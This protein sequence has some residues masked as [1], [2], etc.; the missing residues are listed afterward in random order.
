[1]DPKQM[2]IIEIG[3]G[4]GRLTQALSKFFGEVHALDVSGEMVR[5][6]KA[7]L[8]AIVLAFISTRA[9]AATSPSCLLDLT[10]SLTP[11]LCSNTFRAA[12]LSKI[13]SAK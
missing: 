2:R 3:C 6:A 8:W 10:I 13:T 7:A 1:M 5:Q 11:R 12:R 9:T 4:A